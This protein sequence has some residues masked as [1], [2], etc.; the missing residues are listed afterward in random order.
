MPSNKELSGYLEG[1]TKSD[2]SEISSDQLNASTWVLT[3]ENNNEILKTL[4]CQPRVLSDVFDKI[5][6]GLATS[7][8]DVYFLHNCTEENGIVYGFSNELG[9]I[10][11]IEKGLVRPL[12]KGEDVHRYDNI[13]THRVVVFPYKP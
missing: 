4:Q 12:L 2:F 6:Q 8:D 13:F 9:Q 10:V 5:F 1:L 7:R 3:Q 11:Q